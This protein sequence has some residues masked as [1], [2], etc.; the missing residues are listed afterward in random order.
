MQTSQE[1]TMVASEKDP[2]LRFYLSREP[3]I[4]ALLSA[5]AV[6]SFLAV[7]G[8]SRIYNAQQ[9]SLG[10]RWFTRGAADLKARHF[11]LAVNEFRS[12]LL[13]SPDNYTY[14]LDLAEAL[15]GLKRT[16]EAY[17][18]LI[19]PWERQPENGL[20]NLELA[21]IAAQRGE[22]ERRFVITTMRSTPSGPATRKCNAGTL[23]WS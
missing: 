5:L 6:V 18:Y 21:R 22:T 20:V 14:Q 11:E 12:A 15:I 7:S 17:A 2:G 1:D 13:Y 8:L 19:N 9:Q 16:S 23:A 4:L 3:L 10:N